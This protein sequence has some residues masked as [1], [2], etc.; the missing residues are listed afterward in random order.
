MLRRIRI[1]FLLL[2]LFI[3]AILFP[4]SLFGTE[5]PDIKSIKFINNKAYSDAKLRKLIGTRS[6]SFLKK[7]QFFQDIFIWDLKNISSYYYRR[8]YLDAKIDSVQFRWS[9]D[10][11]E[12]DI[13]IFLDEGSPA[14]IDTV[15]IQGL[16]RLQPEDIRS[17]VK[18]KSNS[19]LDFDRLSVI[20]DNISNYCGNKGHISAS[21]S[22][23]IIRE[24]NRV[25]L[26]YNLNEG[27][28]CILGDV[29]VEGSDKTRKWFIRDKLKLETGDTL[30][31]KAVDNF[32]KTLYQQGLFQSIDVE[33][34]ATPFRH[35]R[36]LRVNVKEKEA[37]EFSFGG[38]YGSEDKLR[39]SG[40]L[41]YINLFGRAT[42]V[43]AI[44]LL[45]VKSRKFEIRYFEPYFFKSSLFFESNLLWRYKIENE[46][47]REVR[48]GIFRIG[49]MLDNNLRVSWGYNYRRTLLTDVIPELAEE[50][51]G[52]NA[53][54][55]FLEATYDR[56]D[57]KIFPKNGLFLSP[58]IAVAEPYLLGD[59]G[60]L[61]L[62]GEIRIYRKVAPSIVLATQGKSEIMFKLE[63]TEI[64]LEE[65][66]FL[67]G[68]NSIRGYETNSLGP[69]TSL[70]NP[71][72]GKFY[73]FWRSEALFNIWKP[74][75]LKFF[76]DNGG[77]YKHFFSARW[78]ETNTGAGIG[79][80]VLFGVWTARVS[81][82]WQFELDEV[83]PGLFHFN[84]GS[85]F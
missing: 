57:N 33:T 13:R 78:D 30:T 39:L 44:G 68:S 59:L 22:R 16:E 70:G 15:I 14:I 6:G 9:P 52:V 1:N 45:S 55:L 17:A 24:E 32:R 28:Q 60:F 64:P 12:V 67:G 81:Y 75:W 35:I 21:L 26:I 2:T 4:L 11:A 63:N 58:R 40:R 74:L 5:R 36:D 72:G 20:E 56:R 41:G 83:K 29:I 62:K 19:Q 54:L 37:G 65:L 31:F 80:Q 61:K 42:G 49:K 46:F 34:E 25:T 47:N 53:S 85:T 71:L 10:S 51:E 84:V 73:Y 23:T 43:G 48:E 38:G 69:L 50:F 3:L 79:L 76:C 66:F 82:A 7:R 77:L 8:G 18:I 27:P